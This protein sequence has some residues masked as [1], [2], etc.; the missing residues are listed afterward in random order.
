[1]ATICHDDVGEERQGTGDGGELLDPPL[2]LELVFLGRLQDL[3]D[4]FAW[5]RPRRRRCSMARRSALP[6]SAS[7]TNS[8]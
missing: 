8:A 4:G 2:A 5:D 1:V 6:S 3:D 7:R